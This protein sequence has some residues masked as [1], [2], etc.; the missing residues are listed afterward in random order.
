MLVGGG[1]LYDRGLLVDCERG[2]VHVRGA[3]Y[4]QLPPGEFA[5]KRRHAERL[6]QRAGD[7]ERSVGVL[8]ARLP[9]DVLDIVLADLGRQLLAV[10]VPPLCD[11]RLRR[12]PGCGLPTLLRRCSRLTCGGRPP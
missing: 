2:T 3:T 6:R 10:P 7:L 11:A 4:A 1:L 5:E 9:F 12:C 8:A